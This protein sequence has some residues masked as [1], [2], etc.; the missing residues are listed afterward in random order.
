MFQITIRCLSCSEIAD[1]PVLVA[2][3]RVLY[4]KLDSATTPATALAPWLPGP[5]MISKLSATKE[6]YD[7]LIHAI[8]TRERSS[9]ARNDTLQ[10]LLDAEDDR[11]LAVGVCRLLCCQ[12]FK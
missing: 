4:D 6:I 1:D 2:R 9:I 3:L 12:R 7:I 10:M 8:D 5:G 11:N